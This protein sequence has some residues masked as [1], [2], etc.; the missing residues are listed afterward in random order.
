[1]SHLTLSIGRGSHGCCP[2]TWALCTHPVCWMCPTGWKDSD[3]AVPV[4]V[5][6][7]YD[8]LFERHG[9][10]VVHCM[11]NIN[12]F[13]CTVTYHGWHMVH[14]CWWTLRQRQICCFLFIMFRFWS[15]KL[16]VVGVYS[17]IPEVGFLLTRTSV[18]MLLW[19]TN[20]SR[21][22]D[23]LKLNLVLRQS[24]LM[25]TT[26]CSTTQYPAWSSPYS[27]CSFSVSRHNMALN[28]L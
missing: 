2:W 15:C 4:W 26:S 7:P 6:K 25:S 8:R 10:Q 11:Y 18:F 27:T 16:I 12:S 20:N 28:F 19:L 24:T 21:H 23:Q 1:M 17:F 9:V 3:V 5:S 22:V 13:N 14:C